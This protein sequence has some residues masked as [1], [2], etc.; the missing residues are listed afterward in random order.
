[1]SAPVSPRTID[2]RAATTADLDALVAL[3]AACFGDEAWDAAAVRAEVEGPHRR[4]VV[5]TREGEPVGYAVVLVAGDVADLLR[6]AT[7]P[8]V[9]RTGVAR[10]LLDDVLA[11]ARRAGADRILL[12]VA[13]TNRGALGFYVAA[14]FSQIDVRPRYYRDGGAALIL[15]RGLGPACGGGER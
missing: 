8:A 7:A 1:M 15:R 11:H 3:E 13:E 2:L 4:V 10:A 14:G 12:E 5:A 6:I 9:R